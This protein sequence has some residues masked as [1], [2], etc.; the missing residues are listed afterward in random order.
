MPTTVQKVRGRGL[1]C[2]EYKTV[3]AKLLL[4]VN[5]YQAQTTSATWHIALY[6][7]V[8]FSYTVHISFYTAEMCIFVPVF[9]R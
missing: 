2:K 7:K 6:L 5:Y 1:T 3:Q 8:N 9:K 4:H